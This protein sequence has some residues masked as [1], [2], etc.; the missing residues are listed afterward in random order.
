MVVDQSF[1]IKSSDK[2]GMTVS[3]RV[4]FDKANEADAFNADLIA[5]YLEHALRHKRPYKYENENC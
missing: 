5:L 4:S 2:N 1:C 3:M